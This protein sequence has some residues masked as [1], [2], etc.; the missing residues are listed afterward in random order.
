MPR[1][2][3]CRVAAAG[4]FCPVPCIAPVCGQITVLG[5]GHDR[6][7]KMTLNQTMTADLNFDYNINDSFRLT[8]DFDL[9]NLINSSFQQNL[10]VGLLKKQE[11]ILMLTKQEIADLYHR[12]K[13]KR[14]I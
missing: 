11:G 9:K 1:S 6:L 10:A 12:G 14:E 8:Q 13:P 2:P 3:S 7:A 4:R 5:G